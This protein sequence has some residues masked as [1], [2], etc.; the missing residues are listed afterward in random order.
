MGTMG[1]R[2][3]LMGEALKV[4]SRDKRVSEELNMHLEAM[5]ELLPRVYGNKESCK[6]AILEIRRVIEMDNLTCKRAMF[7]FGLGTEREMCEY[8]NH[9][10]DNESVRLVHDLRDRVLPFLLPRFYDNMC[11]RPDA[12]VQ[13]V[14]V[15]MEMWKGEQLG[16]RKLSHH[17][18]SIG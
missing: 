10:H 14:I 9:R 15:F 11:Q 13:G 12:L 8:W 16:T 7:L 17:Y 3:I 2:N 4:E 18:A 6:Q 1:L 5:A